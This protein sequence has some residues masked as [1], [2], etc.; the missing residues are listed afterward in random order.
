MRQSI[1]L[2]RRA[3]PI[4]KPSDGGSPDIDSASSKEFVTVI[5]I[6]IADATELS[7]TQTT[8]LI[9]PP[10]S[11]SPNPCRPSSSASDLAARR[12]VSIPVWDGHYRAKPGAGHRHEAPVRPRRREVLLAAA[13]RA[14]QSHSGPC[15]T[16][17][18]P[19][20]TSIWWVLA[21]DLGCILR[22]LIVGRRDNS[23]ATAAIRRA[24]Q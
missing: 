1:D 21:G 8:P 13:S 10:H 6:A 7:S 18:S 4:G 22:Q 14:A 3:Q 11:P 9:A 23:C 15:H 16:E 24:C 19:V 2:P 12:A 20:G 17:S 5:A